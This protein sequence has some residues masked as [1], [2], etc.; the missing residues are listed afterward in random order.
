MGKG[1]CHYWDRYKIGTK[2]QLEISHSKK[3]FI[4]LHYQFLALA[5]PL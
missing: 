2:T 4:K 1:G 5:S 3:K